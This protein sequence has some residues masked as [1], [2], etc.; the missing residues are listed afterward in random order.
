VG[1]GDDITSQLQLAGERWAQLPK[2]KHQVCDQEDLEV[3]TRREFVVALEIRVLA[4][5]ARS[6]GAAS[7][8]CT[9]P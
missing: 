7:P 1:A 8:R 6:T 5:R 3:T 4:P 2:E 9:Q